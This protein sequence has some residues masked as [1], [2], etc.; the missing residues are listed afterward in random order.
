MKSQFIQ[1]NFTNGEISPTA[2]GRFDLAKYAN[3]VKQLE[4]F[5]IKQLGGASFRPGTRFVREIKDSADRCRLLKFLYSTEQTYVIEAGDAYFRFYTDG[6]I[7]LSS[8]SPVEITTPFTLSDLPDIK[9][10]Q[11]ADVMYITTGT[12]IPYKLQRTNATTFTLSKIDFNTV[13]L[14]D[15]NIA[16]INIAPTSATGTTTL[17]ADDGIFFAGHIDS[18]WRVKDGYVKITAVNASNQAVGTVQNNAD[19]TA[20]DLGTTS[21]TK[22]WA[23]AAWSGVRGWPSVVTFHEGRLWFGNTT[24]QPS[25]LWAS[26]PFAYESF[27]EGADDDDEINIE[28]NADTVVSIRWLSSSPK[29]LQCGTSSGIFSVSSGGLG[30]AMTPSNI[31]SSRQ[32]LFGTANIQAKRLFNYVYYVQ[33]DLKRFLESGYFFDIDQNDAV[34]T[35]LLA[36]HI[37][38]VQPQGTI[39]YRGDNSEGGAFEIEAQQSPNNR[40]WVIR[41]DGQ[42][43]VLTRNVRQEINGWSRILA[44]GTSSCDGRSGTGMFES[45][46][47]IP[48]EGGPDQIWVIVNRLINGVEK[49]Y[50]EYFTEEDFKYEWDPVF[51]DCSLTLDNPIDITDIAITDETIVTAPSHG[52]SNGDQIRLDNIVGAY[53]LNGRMFLI[54]DVTTN[55]FKL[56]TEIT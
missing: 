32:N 19:G 23:E 27:P 51:L 39:F 50:V 6:G 48:Q 12:Y 5:L 29:D 44:G 7:L 24:Y 28:L 17:N 52:L 35:T 15:T 46:T 30:Q 14:L 36:D 25:G 26:A 1:N 21:N 18:V 43:I 2:E 16:N 13:P 8:G 37:L 33:N 11:N 31:N 41:D 47:I 54:S 22:D 3:S 34:D 49:R 56:G 20:G 55:T 53:Q 10:A 45:I 38:N 4:N 9:Y 40:I 42:L